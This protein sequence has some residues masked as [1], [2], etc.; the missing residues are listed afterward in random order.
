MKRKQLINWVLWSSRVSI[1]KILILN[2]DYKANQQDLKLKLHI[3]LTNLATGIMF[4]GVAPSCR[5]AHHY[6]LKASS[7]Y[8]VHILYQYSFHT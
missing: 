7:N 8:K 1:Y 6:I 5:I 3:G 2:W 4:M